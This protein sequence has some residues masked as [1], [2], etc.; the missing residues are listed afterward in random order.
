M[1][2]VVTESV[3][4]TELGMNGWRLKIRSLQVCGKVA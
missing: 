4:G 1:L 2:Y 3:Y